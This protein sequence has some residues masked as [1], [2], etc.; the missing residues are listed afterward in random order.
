MPIEWWVVI[1]TVAGPILAVQTQKWIERAGERSKRRQ[2]IFTALLA[3]RATR[4]HDDYVKALNLID[5][6]FAPKRF[7]GAADRKVVEA[8]RS[9]FG[10]LAHAAPKDTADP[11]DFRAWNERSSELLVELLSVMS[12]AVGYTFGKEELRRGIYY[13][14][15]RVDLEQSQLSIMHGLAMIIQG[16]ASLPMRITEIPGSE[17]TAK[18]QAALNEKMVSA[19][20]DDGALK[21]RVLPK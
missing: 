7:G 20:G 15:G 3:N 10:N 11:A 21:I 6:E 4:L 2:W 18:L 17:E 8:W 5:L 14:Q 13:P 16:R 9:L 1:A 12:T 19:Y